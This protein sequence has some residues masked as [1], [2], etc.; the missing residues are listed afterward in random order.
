M[1]SMAYGVDL[2]WVSQLE[3]RGVTW[4]DEKFQTKDPVEL[5]KEL[6]A[7]AVRL[8]IFVDPPKAGFW[9]KPDH[10]TCMLGFCDA[11]SVLAMSQR[12]KALGM[13]LML[14]FHYSD[15]FADPMYQHIP[16][17]WLEEDENGLVKRVYKHTKE[18]LTLFAQN[19]IVPKWVQVGNEINTGI[20]LPAG[21]SKDHPAG[22]V[23]MLNAGYDAVKECCPD[24]IVITHA[25]GFV[26]WDV[27][28]F[29]DRFFENGGKTDLLGL[30][31]YPYW[32]QKEH[33]GEVLKKEFE[34]LLDCYHLPVMIVEIGGL[35]NEEEETYHLLS[36]T[37]RVLKELPKEAGK[38]IFY[39][40]PEVG[41]A[42]LPDH[43]PL[44]AAKV[45][46]ENVLQYTKAL[47]AY[48]N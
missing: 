39:W 30:S 9:E 32:Y 35:E 6:G 10:T 7:N 2:G 18:V 45:V 27:C 16:N 14:D 29:Y 31:Y 21:S 44:G 47:S 38:G 42:L 23:R 11:E 25:A 40:E 5:A 17:A 4:V 46:G 19:G 43:Y 26:G 37:I 20:L 15:H 1:D 33:D 8:R 12:V 13:D 3:G 24:T 34:K 22:L 28:S 36:D 41:A 48:R